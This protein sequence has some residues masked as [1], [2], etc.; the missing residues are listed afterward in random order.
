MN[1]EQQDREEEIFLRALEMAPGKERAA[2][3]EEACAGDSDL[4]LGVEQ[5]FKAHDEPA[6]LL[7][8]TES[9]SAIPGRP[10][11]NAERVGMTVGHYKLLEQLGE[12]GFG[13]VWAA[14]QKK[15][16]RRRVALK[17]IKLGMDTKQV[18]ARFEAE[19]Q[20]LAMM[21]HPNIAKVLDAGTTNEGRLYFVMELVKGIPITEYCD[22]ENLGV[23]SRLELFIKICQAI[24]HAHQKGII[25]RD[26]KPSNIL[27]TLH[28]GVPAPKVIDFGIA[29]ATEGRL[30]DN[31][32][33]TQLNQFIGTPAY[34]SPEQ[35]EMSGLDIDTRSDIYSLGVLLYELL[36]GSTPFDA[37][38]LMA[39][40]IDAMRKTIREKEPQRPS[41][42][43][44]T[45]QGD[46]LTTAAKRRSVESSKLPNLLKGDIDWIVMKCLEKDRDRRYETAN[47]LAADLKRHLNSEP[48][49]ARSPSP[50]YKLRKFIRR[51][52]RSV[53]AAAA[54]V[55][56]LCLG[57][58]GTSLGLVR[59]RA[60]ALRARLA[61]N[62]AMQ[63]RDS[64]NTARQQADQARRDE[65]R[66]N[67]QM[68][69]DRGLALCDQGNVGSGMLWLTR[70]LELA[71]PGEAAMQRVIRANL[72]AWRRELNTLQAIYPHELGVD[73]GT[74]S[75]DGMLV[76]TGA[77]DGVVQLWDRRTG[78]ARIVGRHHAE[79][80]D[81]VFSPDGD[82]F[83][84]A[85]VDKTARLWDTKSGHVLRE[86][87][88]DSG[89]WS[90][91]FTRDG[92]IIT[93]SSGGEIQVWDRD[94]EKPIDAWRDTTHGSV[95][96]LGLS[97]DG[98]QLLGACDD[99]F[100]LL[101]D[102]QTQQVIAR[103][104]G[105]TGR[106]P[107]AVFVGPKRI[108]SADTDGNVFLWTWPQGDAPVNGQRIGDPWQH[109]GGVHRVRV[110][111][112][113]DQLLT[114]SYDNTAQLLDSQTGK[115]IGVPFEH[116]GGL[117]DVAFSKDGTILTACEDDGAREWRPAPGSL[118]G[119]PFA[120]D[121]GTEQALYTPDAK[122]LLIRK[123]K[124]ASIRK[125]LTGERVGMPLERIGGVHGFAISPDESK[126]MTGTA[127]GKV[128]FWQTASGLPFG[129]PFQHR[130]GAWAVAISSDG[131]R[132]VSGGLDGDVT[133]WNVRTGR[134]L[135][136]L[137][138]LGNTPIRGVAFSP[139]GSRI[140]VANADK[141]AWIVGTA[142]GDVPRKLEGHHG[143]V[144]TVA[145]SHDGK[146]VAT[147]SW[148][149]TVV[150]WDAETGLAVSKP[151]RHGGPF[152]YAVSFSGDGRTIVA[153]CDDRTARIWDIDTARPIGP[154]L[155]HDAA[156]RT[157]VFTEDDSQIITGTSAG[158]TY[159]WDVSRSPLEADVKRIELWLQVIT[160]MELE[161]D[162][163]VHPLDPESWQERRKQLHDLGGA[164]SWEE[165][166][167]AETK[168]KAAT[169]PK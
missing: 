166:A 34:M 93:S 17:F 67:F 97:P 150:I 159:N 43:L 13:S 119:R 96:D 21:N 103:F 106:V 168:E 153:G 164:P 61:E 91:L 149:K 144:M 74:I 36:A 25:H 148:D 125:A 116:Q 123:D 58:A 71:P 84:T 154:R 102:L 157:A 3:L 109:R 40:G 130:G 64:A 41:T 160:G 80:H 140:A 76:L 132:A 42:K 65:R 73:T 70:A 143:S 59:T 33:Y 120:N 35:A 60:E 50:T 39:S 88:H 156:L 6:S 147:G 52:R 57:L 142:V 112:N 169:Q 89:V 95:H 139:E 62:A 155:P 47:G 24:Q 85:S 101:W 82:T 121:A 137:P 68:A 78:K 56:V 51:N 54:L 49:L 151:M 72:T 110:S 129:E 5:L 167:A 113:G 16:V 161:A 138:T 118:R 117:K 136:T 19:R 135:R 131:E 105:H 48:V 15:P 108:A 26:I 53:M 4:R 45:L 100:V 46:E 111:A 134:P 104:V 145:F 152:W 14:E 18:V 55:L 163:Q 146:R 77:I 31:T 66:L 126:V 133:L 79:V 115:P 86:F 124:T 30:T 75:P 20:A 7:R 12:G 32:V 114:A 28:D 127:S 128:Q 90:A 141:L 162:G 2:W 8:D 11:A 29:K 81:A 94:T 98:K 87:P 44:A 38:K 9:P 92:R 122:Y 23:R 22:Q 83:L 158:T 165:I 37:K 99:G 69:F 1:N 63:D 27:V 107:T 10:S